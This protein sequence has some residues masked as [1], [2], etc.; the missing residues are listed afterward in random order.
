VAGLTSE[1]EKI[2]SGFKWSIMTSK[3]AMGITAARILHL[4]RHEV[5]GQQ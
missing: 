5:F 4:A 1:A 2:L 3:L